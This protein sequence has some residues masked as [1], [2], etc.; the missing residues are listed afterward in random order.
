LITDVSITLST[1]E[2]DDLATTLTAMNEWQVTGA[3]VQLHPGDI[4]WNWRFGAEATAA[5]VR[6]WSREGQLLAVG[7]IDSPHLLRL[8]IAPQGQD[9]A[10]LA[11]QIHADVSDPERGVLAPGDICLEV[12]C[13]DALRQTLS[14]HG[15][16]DDEP[17]TPLER[18]LSE[19]VEDCGLRIE[20]VGPEHASVRVAVQLAAFDRSTFTEERWH[21][22]AAGPAYADARCLVGYDDQ[23]TAVA[24]VTVWSAGPGRPGLLEPVGVHR[25]HR[26]HG[27]G[28]AISVAAAAALQEL[29]SS[30]ATVC[31]ASANTAAVATYASAGFRR[32]PEVRD[33]RRKA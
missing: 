20:T 17:W 10:A 21:T 31:T 15:W 19:A 33:L 25:D 6:A 3:S 18:D 26:G 5:T 8:A 4:G 9:D 1:P 12:R 32:L 7:M 22:M 13:G 28:M 2:I 11:Q 30:T 14:D 16:Q 29:G 27:Y 24:A 23:D